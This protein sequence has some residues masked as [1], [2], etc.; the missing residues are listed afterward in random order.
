MF[1][2]HLDKGI[3][4]DHEG[5]SATDDELVDTGNSMGPEIKQP[6]ML[7]YKEIRHQTLNIC[8]CSHNF[9][10]VSNE[11]KQALKLAQVP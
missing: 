1:P 10:S 2:T 9:H 6:C 4:V 8:L 5:L 3:Y 11:T 7:A